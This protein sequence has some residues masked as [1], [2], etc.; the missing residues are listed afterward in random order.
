[1]SDGL[2]RALD[3]AG[4]IHVAST[5]DDLR[6][7]CAREGVRIVEYAAPRKLLARELE[8]R[9]AKLRTRWIDHLRASA[10]GWERLASA[11]E[12][13][14]KLAQEQASGLRAMAEDLLWD[15]SRERGGMPKELPNE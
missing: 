5:L 9:L 6:A 11:G 8:E 7:W 2:W 4:K 1:M 10:S 14:A 15:A 13:R 3:E 12:V